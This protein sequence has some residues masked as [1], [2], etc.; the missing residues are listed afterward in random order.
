MKRGWTWDVDHALRA[1]QVRLHQRIAGIDQGDT[2]GDER[3]AVHIGVEGGRGYRPDAV[4]ALGHRDA[5]PAFAAEHHFLGVG[6]AEAE[7]NGAIGMDLGRH[8]GRGRLLRQRIGGGVE[9]Q[10]WE[11]WLHGSNLLH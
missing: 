1:E 3:V 9:E 2:V 11:P 4:I 5:D 8:D 6:R 10:D 7:G